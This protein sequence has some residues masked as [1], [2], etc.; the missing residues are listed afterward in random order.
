LKNA[1]LIISKGME[2]EWDEVCESDESD[3]NSFGG[4]K[5]KE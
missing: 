4:N 2:F 1:I 5:W 3:A